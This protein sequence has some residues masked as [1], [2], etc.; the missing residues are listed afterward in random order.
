MVGLEGYE[1]EAMPA[2]V[3]RGLLREEIERLLPKGALAA[4]KVAERSEREGLRVLA[5][6]VM[7]GG[8]LL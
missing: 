5:Q 6:R 3:L 7:K 1:A 4:A 2:R 8:A